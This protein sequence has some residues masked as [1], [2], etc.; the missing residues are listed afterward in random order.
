MNRQTVLS[1]SLSPSANGLDPPPERPEVA[2][3]TGSG[4]CLSGEI[5]CLLHSRLRVATVIMW[6]GFTVFFVRQLVAGLPPGQS[7]LGFALHGGVVAVLTVL[8]AILWL[9]PVIPLCWLR[10]IELGVFGSA[11]AFFAWLQYDQFSSGH[12]L[13]FAHTGCEA[14]VLRMAAGMSAL[15]WFILLVTYGTFIPNTWKRCAVVVGI[16][17]LA[18]VLITGGFLLF[19]RAAGPYLADGLLDTATL[20]VIG[21][22]IAVFGSH[23]ISTLHQEAFAAKQL[24]QYRLKERLGAGGMGE[25]YLAEHRF[26]RRPCAIKL[27]RPEQAGDPKTLLRFEREVQAT[28]AL[29]HW[30]TVEIYDYGRTADGTFY[31]VMEYLPGLSLEELVERYGP[32]PP[33]RAIHLLR[34]VCDALREAH[35]SGLI[36][37][38]IKPSNVIACE[39]GG[40]YDVAKLLDFGLVQNSGLRGVSAKL[41]Q[42]GA[43][44]GSPM[45]M[46]PEQARGQSAL[47]ARTDIYNLGAVAYFM[48][49]GR[50][51]FVRDSAIE[52][53]AAHLN[54]PPPRL[55]SLRADIP[56]DLEAVVLRCLEKNPADRFQ[57]AESL[58]R[59]L[60]ACACADQ[61]TRQD[62]AAWW[63]QL[64]PAPPAGDHDPAVLPTVVIPA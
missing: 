47:D 22:A 1:G 59:A 64:P 62:A 4:P 23:K 28:A 61:W 43:V 35:A 50:P 55:T 21:A 44:A 29:T 12:V 53:L 46:S 57:D 17:A 3:V 60:A 54:E 32:L 24:G 41:T 34:Q 15:R 33:A 39:R 19:D 58:E 7:P 10:L 2:L 31:Y 38:D 45:Y 40:V 25:V 56:A 6:V 63:R 16:I 27:I 11:A 49:T 37:R 48:L 5:G 8:G 20:M 30:N 36:H 52:L 26:L 18:P 13:A 14:H 42:E 9:R 51:P